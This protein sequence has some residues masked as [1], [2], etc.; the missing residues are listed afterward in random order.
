MANHIKDIIEG[1]LCKTKTNRQLY[2]D[3]EGI[4]TAI[5]DG[6][7]RKHV[8]LQSITS[9]AVVLGARSS[10]AVYNVNLKK[11]SILQEIKKTTTQIDRIRVQ[12]Q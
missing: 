7:T 12:V 5:L 2:V 1:F 8:S 3:I 9:R 4:L 6:E 11:E 10:S